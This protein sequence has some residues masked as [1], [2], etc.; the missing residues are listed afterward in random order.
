MH[1]GM[2]LQIKKNHEEARRFLIFIWVPLDFVM[3]IDSNFK[4][5]YTHR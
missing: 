5:L 1:H 2:Y 4:Y 3:D